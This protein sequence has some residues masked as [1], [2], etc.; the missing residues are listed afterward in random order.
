[1]RHRVDR[2]RHASRQLVEDEVGRLPVVERPNPSPFVLDEQGR[3]LSDTFDA[4]LEPSLRRFEIDQCGFDGGAAAVQGQDAHEGF[5]ARRAKL[6]GSILTPG[7]AT[8]TPGYVE[9]RIGQREPQA[10]D[11]R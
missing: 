3:G 7:T 1:M 10:Y 5:R 8:Q 6:E 4:R 9:V 11:Q 2:R